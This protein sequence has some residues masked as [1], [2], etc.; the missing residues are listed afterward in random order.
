MPNKFRNEL[1]GGK[2]HSP[3]RG[4]TSTSA[5][6]LGE[7]LMRNECRLVFWTVCRSFRYD[8]VATHSPQ[9][10]SSRYFASA[11]TEIS[12]SILGIFQTSHYWHFFLHFSENS[13]KNCILLH[14]L[15]FFILVIFNASNTLL[16]RGV[17]IDAGENVEECV[18]FPCYYFRLRFQV[19]YYYDPTKFENYLFHFYYSPTVLK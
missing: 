19:K 1:F 7:K 3:L 2:W 5:P 16:V 12:C 6:T 13:L 17:Y 8:G 15:S 11:F 4:R 9:Y 18:E 14:F 10:L